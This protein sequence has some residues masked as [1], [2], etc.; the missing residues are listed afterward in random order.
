MEF[1]GLVSLVANREPITFL[2]SFRFL[3]VEF[4]G[5]RLETPTRFDI[6]PGNHFLFLDCLGVASGAKIDKK[7]TAPL[8]FIES[9]GDQKR[10]F[11]DVMLLHYFPS[12]G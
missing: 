8:T 3:K 11:G 5:V 9:Q 1:S 2:E 12:G 6:A 4:S 10:T 7:S